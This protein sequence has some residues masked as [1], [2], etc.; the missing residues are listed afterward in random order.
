MNTKFSDKVF[1]AF[2]ILAFVLG[3][4]WTPNTT[5]R[6]EAPSPIIWGVTPSNNW[7]SGRSWPS[8]VNIQIAINDPTTPQDPDFLENQITDASGNF[9]YQS[10]FD[11]KVGFDVYATDGN[12][13][14]RVAI[15]NFEVTSIDWENDTISGIGTPNANAAIWLLN[16]WEPFMIDSSGHWRVDLAG[17]KDITTEPEDQGFAI[18]QDDDGD[19]TQSNWS[20]PRFHANPGGY[21]DNHI[22]GFGW[23]A[24]STIILTI[25]DPSTIT[26][27]DYS[28]SVIASN[29]DPWQTNARFTLQ[30]FELSEGQIVTLTGNSMT[31][32]LVIKTL[33]ITEADAMSD[34]VR[35]I[36]E[37]GSVVRVNLWCRD[38]PFR[39]ETVDSNG[40]WM[41]DFSTPGDQIGE[42]VS[43][44]PEGLQIGALLADEDH[45]ATRFDLLVLNP[46]LSA[47]LPDNAVAGR[48][49]TLGESVTLTID[50]PK[51]S[52]AIDY[53]DTRTVV[54]WDWDPSQTEVL[55]N[56]NNFLLEPGQVLTMTNGTVTK[57]HTVIDLKI[58]DVNIDADI[59]S[60]TTN[61]FEG[62]IEIY[63][64]GDPPTN[65]I[66]NV[67]PDGTWLADF[68]IPHSSQDNISDLRHGDV[69]ESLHYDEDGD[70]TLVRW[71]VPELPNFHVRPNQNEIHAFRWSEGNQVHVT[72]DDP[73]TPNPIDYEE[74][75]EA[76]MT[77]WF[78][79]M[80][81]MIFTVQGMTLQS[82]QIVT[83]TDGTTTKA[84]VIQELSVISASPVTDI[85]EG[86]AA[87]N[88]FVHVWENCDQDICAFRYIQA[89]S[90]GVWLADFSIP[91]GNSSP[92]EQKTLDLQPDSN[93]NANIRDEDGDFTTWNWRVLE[94]HIYIEP[95]EDNIFA[96]DWPVGT[97]L[98]LT[99]DDP[100]TPDQTPDYTTT[101]VSAGFEDWDHGFELAGI[102]DIQPGY[103]VTVS[104]GSTAKLHT[105]THLTIT[106]I[107][108]DTDTISGTADPDSFVHVGTMCDED[109]C[110]N[111]NLIVDAT[112]NW[113]VDFST[114]VNESWQGMGTFDLRLGSG[115]SVFEHDEDWDSTKVNWNVY[116]PT[117]GVDVD[118]DRVQGWDWPLGA[119]VSFEIDDPLT[120]ENP[121]YIN[122]V[123]VETA[124][125][126]PNLMYF[127]FY[128]NEYDL[129]PG[130]IVTATDGNLT[131]QLIVT[132]FRITSV[133]LALDT[134]YGVANPGQDV[135]IWTY[136]PYAHDGKSINREAIADSN[137]N[138][139]ANFGIPGD[140][141]SEQET[142]DIRNGWGFDS[143]VGDEDWDNT[144]SMW[145]VPNPTIGIRTNYDQVETYIWDI[146]NILTLEIDNPATTDAPDY[147]A[148]QIVTDVA[149]WE[150]SQTYVLFDLYGVYDIQ[151]GDVVE[152]SNGS[153]TKTTIVGNLAITNVHLDTDMVEGTAEPNQTINVWTCW[154]DSCTSRDETAD[155]YG[156]WVTNF[157]SP[158]EQDWEQEIADLRAGSWIDSSVSDEDDDYMAFGWYVSSA[159]I[160]NAGP[161]QTSL[162]ADI[163][164]LDA[165]ASSDPDADLLTYQW[166]LDND[167]DY[168]DA[169]GITTSTTFLDNRIYIVGLKVTDQN[170][171]FD[172]DIVEINVAN[173]SPSVTIQL[174]AAN[175]LGVLSGNGLFIDPGADTWTASVNYGDGTVTQS[176]ALNLDKS[177]SLNHTYSSS[178]DYMIEACISDDDGGYGCDQIQVTVVTNH[179]PVADAGGPYS[180]NE[181]TTINLSASKS[182]DPDNSIVLYEWDLDNDGQFDDATAKKPKFKA[183]DNGIFTVRVRVTDAG[184]LSS[185]DSS[186]VTVKNVPP[187]IT[188][189]TFNSSVRVGVKINA[190][191]IFKD[192]GIND[193][194]T[195]KWK[196]GDGTTSAGAISGNTVNGSHTYT[197]PGIYL[198]TIMVKDK[199]GGVGQAYKLIFVLPKR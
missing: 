90:N 60:G 131:K 154:Q 178:G 159:P 120:P 26:T 13:I 110:A 179:P 185:E 109:G 74:T 50:D 182:I 68:S 40:A 168:D 29:D 188:S 171:E 174:A 111:R 124:D 151:I 149:P 71:I 5:S 142:V 18:E 2:M 97:L 57:V 99:I 11:I 82:G 21:A 105:V 145:S 48:D 23:P 104:D 160:A 117:I 96:W 115:G 190:Y 189:L 186:T 15:T 156:Y 114:P 43:D 136:N 130:D 91:G 83:M 28:A 8:A 177:F 141:D 162:E 41:A 63:S 39:V 165:S 58:T 98:T 103:L 101:Q 132:H 133:D 62:E 155:A 169:V 3:T 158:G 180:G 150:P 139:F 46:H 87:P 129:K 88:E 17:K 67:N 24:G 56:L 147:T 94:P 85:V 34:V 53:S 176:L 10:T 49:W 194:F 32:S 59:V 89:D 135:K 122:S 7:I 52:Q 181:G 25:E 36:A 47:R 148:V 140:E 37:P 119:T 38:C 106:N 84:H 157:A 6:A 79:D 138:W 118:I 146:G 14:K 121:D 164:T 61:V 196:W 69:S 95:N 27:P 80:T 152:I 4:V 166:D 31:K 77:E 30:S 128:T 198:V 86:R 183:V 173:I 116:N 20:V 175:N 51:T 184:G 199:D 172:T 100:A 127:V 70:F 12:T 72:V 144:R 19:G 42:L 134:V 170:A 195:A 76:V 66:I 54:P 35:G 65:R 123:T 163:V 16:W 1:R 126:D 192:V 137:G 113:L 112:G 55:F 108:I 187:V 92:E 143:F 78:D 75:Q 73:S 81:F 161:D 167:G 22:D 45:D 153:I 9:S 93:G 107:D 64:F 197:K 44:I 193:T 33:Q 102:F 191:A 125:W